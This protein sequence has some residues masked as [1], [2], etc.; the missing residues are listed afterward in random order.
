LTNNMAYLLMVLLSLLMPLSMVVRFQHG[1]YGT[2]FLDLPFCITATISVCFFYIATQRELGLNWW[3]RI[4]YLPFLVLFQ[5]GFL[6]VGLM[7]LFQNRVKSSSAKVAAIPSAP[8]QAQ[9][10]A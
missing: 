7:S 9:R 1:L 5:M 8:E 3:G 4:K 2:L 6:Y 10:A